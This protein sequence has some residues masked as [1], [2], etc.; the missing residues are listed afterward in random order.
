MAST[1]S[2]LVLKRLKTVCLKRATVRLFECSAP[3]TLPECCKHLGTVNETKCHENDCDSVHIPYGKV[4]KWYM[5]LTASECTVYLV[6][7]IS[8]NCLCCCDIFGMHFYC[9]W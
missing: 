6:K 4:L 3:S 7:V 1:D 5:G 8:C 2:Q 9:V